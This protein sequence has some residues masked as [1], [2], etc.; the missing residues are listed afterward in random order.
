MKAAAKSLKRMRAD[1]IL[2]VMF[3]PVL[4]N[5]IIFHYAPMFGIVI[6]FK[7]Y[8][9]AYTIAQAPWVGLQ[10]FAAFFNSYYFWDYTR[11]TLTI[12]LASIIVG[13][14]MPIL[15]ALLMNEIRVSGYKRVL[16]TVT[17]MPYFISSVIVV[18]LVTML[19]NP[20]DGIV[21]QALVYMGFNSVNFLGTPALFVPVYLSMAIWQSTGFG[22]IIYLSAISAIDPELYEA[23]ILDGAGR[24]A[25]IWHITVKTILPTIAIMFILRL[26]GILNV[27]WL[28]ILLM[29]NTMNLSASEVIQTFV[30]KRGIVGAD[31]S[32][33]TAVGVIM[34][35][36][37]M[38]MIIG[39]NRVVKKMTDSEMSLF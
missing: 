32:Y 4:L 14:P 15:L 30:Y 21:N 20:A 37:G 38:V 39:S 24:F 12:S 25:R 2:Y 7:N 13:F 36:I 23:A 19:L 33:S 10:K 28:E 31:Y 3:L 9:P 5:F 16:Q 6:A 1:I 8:H 17:Y 18:G 22:A 35:V 29:Q 11:N 27:G 26:G 34:S